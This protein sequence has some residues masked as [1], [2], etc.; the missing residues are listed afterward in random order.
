MCYNMMK[1]GDSFKGDAFMDYSVIIPV[2]NSSGSLLE[3]L[4]EVEGFF[5]TIGKSHEVIFIDDCSQDGSWGIIEDFARSRADVKAIRFNRNKGQQY[6]LL[7]GLEMAE[8]T[9]AVTID[10]DLQ[11]DINDLLRM[12]PLTEA[13]S[14]LVFGIYEEY[15][16]RGLRS[17]GSKFIGYI[18]RSRFHNL[19]KMR[20][21]SFRL[22]HNTVF[23][24]ALK[25]ERAF[26][27]LS[28]ELLTHCTKVSNVSV[29]RRSRIYG[30]S[31]YTLRKCLSIS[32]K[33]LLYY[34][35]YSKR[36]IRKVDENEENIDGWCGKLP[37][38]R[39]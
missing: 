2:Y 31:G 28:A 21:S 29:T 25:E 38:Q 19:G 36:F 13:G 26:T 16:S 34:G 8:G 15:G 10:D 3:L 33:I 27:Y 6:A 5:K 1:V 24:M 23:T 7:K 35:R 11:H 4:E 39:N 30:K 12:I 9:Y 37:A 20:V 32:L 18:L 17:F 22:I 14:D